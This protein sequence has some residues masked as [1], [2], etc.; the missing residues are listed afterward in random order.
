MVVAVVARPQ[1]DR[2]EP[3]L[4]VQLARGQV[5]QPHLERRL[6]G[7]AIDREVEEGQQQPLP[8]AL[9][10]PRRVDRER[11]DV[12]L[13]DH[14]PHAAV[15]DDRV[16]RPGDQIVGEAV[17]LELAA[18]GVRRPRRGEARELDRVDGRQVLEPH[19]LDDDPYRWSRDHA[20]VPSA[21]RTPRG[22][23]TYSGTSVSS[24]SAP[25]PA[26]ARRRA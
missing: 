18:V 16:T 24:S 11:R 14:Q 21:A 12:R 15:C 2:P 6:V 5:R 13:V 1:A 17:R 4:L 10:A 26:A 23:V 22:S 3:V 8:D 9:P 7:A 25:L 19:R 20:T